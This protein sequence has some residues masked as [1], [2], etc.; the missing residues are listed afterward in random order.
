[1]RNACGSIRKGVVE[2]QFGDFAV[3]TK[4]E[5][6]KKKNFGEGEHLKSKQQ[7][8]A[9]QE[10]QKRATQKKILDQLF[11]YENLRGQEGERW[12]SGTGSYGV[13]EGGLKG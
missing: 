5:S 1:V 6:G 3:K 10:G 13:R 7:S 2:E 8:G 4:E 9:R 11:G 12:A